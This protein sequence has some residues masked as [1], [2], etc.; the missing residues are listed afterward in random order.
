MAFFVLLVREELSL[1]KFEEILEQERRH[2][3]EKGI[4]LRRILLSMT[5]H[6]FSFRC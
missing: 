5:E 3:I 1:A 2:Q 4:F 6:R